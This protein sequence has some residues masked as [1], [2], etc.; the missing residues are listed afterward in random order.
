MA[1]LKSQRHWDG[2]EDVGGVTERSAQFY[3]KGCKLVHC[4]F[5]VDKTKQGQ[6]G[7]SVS[8]TLVV[9]AL[10]PEVKLKSHKKVE[11]EK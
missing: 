10:Y 5:S 4:F 7:G 1:N 11:G 9:K 3:P 2:V 8:K 6:P